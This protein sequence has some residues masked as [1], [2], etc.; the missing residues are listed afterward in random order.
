MNDHDIVYRTCFR[1][2]TLYAATLGPCHAQTQFCP[3]CRG[4]VAQ[5]CPHVGKDIA[6]THKEEGMEVRVT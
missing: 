5:G 3:R 6:G 4:L 2:R 1:C